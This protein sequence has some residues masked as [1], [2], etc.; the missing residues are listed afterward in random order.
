MEIIYGPKGT[1]KTKQ[2]IDRANGVLES[3]KGHAVFITDTTRYSYDL[4]YQIKVL[5]V[6]AFNV[7]GEESFNGFVKGIVAAS[8]DN[9]YIFIDGIAR[10]C[11]KDLSELG[12][13]FAD[14]ESLEKEY[15]VKFIITCSAQKEE[16]PEFV[17]KCL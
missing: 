6:K 3:A 10:I 9:E 14:I 5:D 17:A 1:G 2:I 7:Q 13:I 15:G 4:K 8:G 16:L 12:G 11:K